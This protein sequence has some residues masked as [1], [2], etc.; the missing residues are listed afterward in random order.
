MIKDI[1]T[2]KGLAEMQKLLILVLGCA[3]QVIIYVPVLCFEVSGVRIERCLFYYDTCSQKAKS[4]Q[5]CFFVNLFSFK[6]MTYF[7]T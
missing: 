2:P 7:T 3:V 5:K 6:P 1:R 4:S